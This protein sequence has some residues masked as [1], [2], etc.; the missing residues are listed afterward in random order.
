MCASTVVLQI[1]FD[2]LAEL[3]LLATIAVIGPGTD[4]GFRGPD[5]VANCRQMPMQQVLPGL[6][7]YDAATRL[8][9]AVRVQSGVLL[10]LNISQ[11]FEYFA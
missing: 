10:S 11:D 2:E 4:Q 3:H 9:Q 8:D 6:G 1:S 5:L 7:E